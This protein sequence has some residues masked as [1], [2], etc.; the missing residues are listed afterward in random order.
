MDSEN[1]PEAP[2][3][4]APTPAP[5]SEAPAAA[6]T[7]ESE[8]AN[9]TVG[10]GHVAAIGGAARAVAT[11]ARKSTPRGKRG[12]RLP[13]R[14]KKAAPGS[15]AGI[16]PH[17][18]TPVSA[19]KPSVRVTCID[20]SP[21]QAVFEE[22]QDLPAFIAEHRDGLVVGAL[23]QRGRPGRPGGGARRSRR[24]TGCT[25]WRS[26]TCCTCRSVPRCRPTRTTATTRRA[27]SS[28]RA[29][30]SCARGSCTPSR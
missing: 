6:V 1:E 14:F 7:T 30:W 24:S 18:L 5:E 13:R 16:E 2:D 26:R 3:S 22:I 21:Q 23:D 12:L 15:A 4:A 28:S 17:E 19:Q 10:Q 25:R 27:C 20:Y 11:K 8:G 9:G 29:S